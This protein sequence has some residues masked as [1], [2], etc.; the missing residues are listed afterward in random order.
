MFFS[1]KMN[2]AKV[3]QRRNEE[4]CNTFVLPAITSMCTYNVLGVKAI[5]WYGNGEICPSFFLFP[6]PSSLLFHFLPMK[7]GRF[8]GE[9]V[10]LP[11]RK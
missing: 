3:R 7:F 9:F 8:R 2:Q 11:T 6:F 4:A 10:T 1:K 5:G